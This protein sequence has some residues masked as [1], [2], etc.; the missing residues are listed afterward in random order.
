MPPG[1]A[2]IVPKT[3]DWQELRCQVGHIKE[4]TSSSPAKSAE[5]VTIARTTSLLELPGMQVHIEK[6]AIKK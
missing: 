2:N 3:G 5:F 4:E 6:F 1:E